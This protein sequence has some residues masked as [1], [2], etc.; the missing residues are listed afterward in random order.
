MAPQ[1]LVSFP[2]VQQVIA[3][4]YVFTPGIAPGVAT[5]DI[6][7]QPDAF[8]SSGTLEFTFASTRITLPDCRV[9]RVSFRQS[10]QGLVYRLRINDRR[11]RWAF[12]KISG[13]YNLRRDDGTIV[14]ESERSPSE[15]ARLCLDA[16]GETEADLSELPS[17]PRPTVEWDYDNP[18]AAL[19][20]LAAVCGCR[21]VLGLDNRIRLRSL[22]ASTELP[23][24]DTATVYGR[25]AL[26]PPGPDVLAVTT[27]RVR[28]QADFPL[29]AVALDVDG[30]IRR[31]DDLS[32]RP[33]GGWSMV[34]LE[35]FQ[36]I[37]DPRARELALA[38]VFRWYRIATPFELPSAGTISDLALILPIETEQVET[39]TVADGTARNRPAVVFGVWSHYPS[40]AVNRVNQLRPLSAGGAGDPRPVVTTPFVIDRQRAL[41][42]FQA[43]VIRYA[44]GPSPAPA[45]LVLRTAVGLR[46]PDTRAWK[47]W[48]RAR[49][50]NA[51]NLTTHYI[52]RNDLLP[53]VVAVYDPDSY[54]LVGCNTNFTTIAAQADATLDAAAATWQQRQP[55]QARYAGLAPLEP[56]GAVDAVIWSVGPEGATTEVI[57]HG[58][59]R[60]G[61]PA[62][63]SAGNAIPSQPRLDTQDARRQLKH[64]TV[65]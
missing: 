53:S 59:R 65:A 43:P 62:H 39:T 21:A 36:A 48:E 32:Y 1:G 49:Q 52:K 3:A 50:I 46:D 8:F 4:R 55:Q 7:P 34:D 51:A 5:I 28:F 64:Q 23:L 15:L 57:R 38:S 12:G 56:D 27:G 33:Y 31:L 6:A 13:S 11:W 19:A 17:E 20:W 42:K 37:G 40:Q 25:A 54:R 61:R 41:V 22:S 47:R 26:N 18:A 58:Q 16:M 2:G 30:E 24:S 10:Q 45:Q 9:E 60:T 44:E 63:G 14:A 29:E 35:H